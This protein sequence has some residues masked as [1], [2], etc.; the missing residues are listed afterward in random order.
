MNDKFLRVKEKLQREMGQTITQLLTEKDVVEIML[1][2][3]GKLWVERLGQEMQPV[4]EMVA[5]Q[6]ES[7]MATVASTINTTITSEKPI[8]ECELPIDGSRFE[9]LIPPIVSAP[10]F[11]IRKKAYKIFT[12][13]D[14]VNDG[15]MS[16][17]QREM[18]I[19]S[20]KNRKNILVVGG[21]GTGKTT[22]TNAIIEAIS[23][24]TPDHR[25]AII[26]DTGEIQCSSKNVVIM[27]STEHVSMLRLL[28]ATMRLRPDRILV[29]EVRGEEALALLKAWNTGH[30]GGVA[31]VHAND[32]RAGLI[33]MEQLI[34]EATPA[35]QQQL[36]AEA[37]D[38]VICI[39]KSEGGR[40]VK[41]IISVDG[42]RNNDYQLTTIN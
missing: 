6:A 39:V 14:Y 11:T 35:P 21:T 27:R 31:T 5:S 36:I 20:V 15:I 13:D 28:K 32:A 9:A 34:S 22:L 7:L 12:L 19:S 25:L 16:S 26:E 4:G 41:E 3:D 30:P 2:P 37:V 40:K 24:Y 33:R 29:G 42:Y 17:D 8:L 23:T 18:I 1:N 10:T 38:V